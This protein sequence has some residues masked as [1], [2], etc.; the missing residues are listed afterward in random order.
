MHMI[1]I[2]KPM[3]L[4]VFWFALT[5]LAIGQQTATPK[6]PTKPQG[7]SSAVLRSSSTGVGINS[8]SRQVD[9]RTTSPGREVSTQTIE[10]QGNDGRFRTDRIA[11]TETVG[12]GTK[13]VQST[14]TV[15]GTTA[16]GRQ[17]LVQTTQ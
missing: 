3:M 9:T 6:T 17:I 16:D 8:M 7:T 4:V 15:Y 10:V 5:S 12:I 2:I 14:Q 11:T 13:S 1:A